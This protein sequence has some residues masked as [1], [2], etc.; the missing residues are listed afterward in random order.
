ML[1]PDRAV[2][3][4]QRESLIVADVHLGK[5]TAFRHAGVPVPAGSSSKDLGRLSALM[6]QTAARRLVILG[7]L[8]HGRTSHQREL[9]DSIAEWRANH[10]EIEMLLV[11]GNH[12][13]SAGRLPVEWNIPEVEEPVADVILT[14]SHVPRYEQAMPVLAGHLHPVKSMQDFDRSSVRVPCFHESQRCLVLPAFGSFTG[15]ACVNL[16]EGDRCFLTS[17]KAVVQLAR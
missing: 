3:W 8:I 14:L 7:D 4:P 9:C 17:G 12:D 6:Q 15:G 2:Y 1:L 10:A 5:G 16:R 11:R 13:R